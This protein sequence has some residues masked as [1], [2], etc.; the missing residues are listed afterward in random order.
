MAHGFWQLFFNDVEVS[1]IDNAFYP[2]VCYLNTLLGLDMSSKNG[3][4]QAFGYYADSGVQ[5]QD[6]KPGGLGFLQRREQ[7][8]RMKLV[9]TDEKFVYYEKARPFF[10]RLFTSLTSNP[11]PIVSG[12]AARVE[13]L[14]SAKEFPVL[15]AEPDAKTQ[16]YRLKMESCSLHLPVK[17][18]ASSLA[19][20]LEKR[21]TSKP[22]VLSLTRVETKLMSIASSLQ[23][24]E[25][26]TLVQSSVIPK[27]ML[28]ALV[29]NNTWTPDYAVNPF[30]YK[31]VFEDTSKGTTTESKLTKLSLSLNQV[32]LE[33]DVGGDHDVLVMQ[34]FLRLYRGLGCL[35]KKSD[36]AVN[37]SDF[38]SAQGFH[39]FDLTAAARASED[40]EAAQ[41]QK[42]GHLR[43][44]IGFSAPL[45]YQVNVLCLS[46]FD[47]AIQIQKN[48]T[49]QYN[50][51]Q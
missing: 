5:A 4:V 22:I 23:S 33:P 20:D 31:N 7:F 10:S 25:C 32:P 48:R 8:G 44:S 9:G 49:V 17:S 12:I 6:L 43:L 14:H 13:L 50:Y 46:E 34:A 51:L 21:L 28:I 2:V 39:L 37:F 45:P 47:A 3:Q 35:N 41:P 15:C 38:S 29:K 24:Y 30:D 16:G 18:M 19:L 42:T 36:P 11:L 27:R 1:T 26:D 40:G